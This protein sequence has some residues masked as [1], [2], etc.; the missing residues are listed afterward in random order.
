MTSIREIYRTV[1]MW[2]QSTGFRNEDL[3]LVEAADFG[4]FYGFAF[5]A[6]NI[7]N[8]AYWCVDKATMKLTM[9]LPVQDPAAYKARIKINPSE[10]E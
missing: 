1:R 9:F 4:K 5:K 2:A 7:Y 10:L 6:E 3:V 8:N